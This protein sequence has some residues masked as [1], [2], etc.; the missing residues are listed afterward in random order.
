MNIQPMQRPAFCIRVLI[1]RVLLSIT[2][3]HAQICKLGLAGAPNQ[4]RPS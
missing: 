1:G 3:V 4:G 2:A